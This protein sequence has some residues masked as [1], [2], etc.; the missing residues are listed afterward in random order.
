VVIEFIHSV[1]VFL[2]RYVKSHSAVLSHVYRCVLRR[3]IMNH[4][5]HVAGL[6]CAICLRVCG[7]SGPLVSCTVDTV[8]WHGL[9]FT[10]SCHLVFAR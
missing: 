2:F 5:L 4:R 10:W 8:F 6:S 1:T 3:R 9:E 7:V